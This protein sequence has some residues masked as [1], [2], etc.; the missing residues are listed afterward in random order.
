MSSSG[1]DDG[2]FWVSWGVG[3][4]AGIGDNALLESMTHSTLT[5]YTICTSLSPSITIQDLSGSFWLWHISSGQMTSPAS[6]VSEVMTTSSGHQQEPSTPR[7]F[8]TW[9]LITQNLSWN[10]SP[11]PS[12]GW[13]HLVFRE[14]WSSTKHCWTSSG[15]FGV[16]IAC[17]SAVDTLIFQLLWST[18][19][20]CLGIPLLP[21][22]SLQHPGLAK[23]SLNFF[24]IATCLELICLKWTLHYQTS[25]KFLWL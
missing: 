23:G 17:A 9:F 14:G 7:V 11:T 10:L 22:R 3:V 19:H 21:Q 18:A 15:G 8:T 2:Y 5:W 13:A 6:H 16:Y 12:S 25:S 1:I 20:D 4:S 24:L